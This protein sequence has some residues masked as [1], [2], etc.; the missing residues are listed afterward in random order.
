MVYLFGTSL[1]DGLALEDI[2]DEQIRDQL[3]EVIRKRPSVL[4]LV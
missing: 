2:R 3:N 1:G 4:L